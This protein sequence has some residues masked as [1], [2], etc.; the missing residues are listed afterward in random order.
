MNL[1]SYSIQFSGGWYG[2]QHQVWPFP[3]GFQV[4]SMMPLNIYPI[5]NLV[6][7][8]KLWDTCII[9]GTKFRPQFL[10]ADM[11]SWQSSHKIFVS[12]KSHSG[13]RRGQELGSWK[14][15]HQL[16]GRPSVA[17][18]C[19]PETECVSPPLSEFLWIQGGGLNPISINHCH[20]PGLTPLPFG[21]VFPSLQFPTPLLLFVNAL[22]SPMAPLFAICALIGLKGFS[23][24]LWLESLF[25]AFPN[26]CRQ[27]SL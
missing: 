21:G 2:Q 13:G 9:Q 20:H 17:P 16:R 10:V 22:S 23:I 6:V 15:D 3:L 27:D 12:L 8:W 4:F 14:L 24:S 11:E 5:S 19:P 7:L 18:L 26:Y 1:G 25:S